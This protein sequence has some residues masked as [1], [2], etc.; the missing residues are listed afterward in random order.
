MPTTIVWDNSH[1]G[2]SVENTSVRNRVAEMF[3]GCSA[4]SIHLQVHRT[5]TTVQENLTARGST[6]LHRNPATAPRMFSG[7]RHLMRRDVY[8]HILRGL[9]LHHMRI[10][11]AVH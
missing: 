10:A 11:V 5:V 4:Q 8:R 7:K 6:K 9:Q 3:S 2:N 1:S